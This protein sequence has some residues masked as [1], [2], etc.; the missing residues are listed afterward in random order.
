M[1]RNPRGCH[2]QIEVLAMKV[3]LEEDANVLIHTVGDSFDATFIAPTIVL[4]G[5]TR[6]VTNTPLLCRWVLF[7][8]CVRDRDEHDTYEE[9]CDATLLYVFNP[10]TDVLMVA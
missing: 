2:R 6:L 10:N 8:S 1:T 9:F 7:V 5:T 4:L 3:T